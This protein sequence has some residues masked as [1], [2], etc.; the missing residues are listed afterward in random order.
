MP[1]GLNTYC[2]AT[3]IKQHAIIWRHAP[4]LP[5]HAFI[6]H[7][8]L[9]HDY[10]FA[11]APTIGIRYACWVYATALL[12]LY[13]FIG[14]ADITPRQYLNIATLSD[15]FTLHCRHCHMLSPLWCC[16]CQEPLLRRDVCQHRPHIATAMLLRYYFATPTRQYCQAQP[17]AIDIDADAY[18]DYCR[19]NIF[20]TAADISRHVCR[21]W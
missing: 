14:Y 2:Y 9:L 11:A 16:R 7:D 10:I 18:A 19:W 15:Y 6:R 1:P 21:H 12:L 3:L 4:T 5:R 17:H 20:H 13:A 8:E